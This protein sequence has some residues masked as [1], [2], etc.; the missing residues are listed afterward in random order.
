M[1]LRGS[2][3]PRSNEHPRGLNNIVLQSRVYRLPCDLSHWS[4][5]DLHDLI[6]PSARVGS[7][8]LVLSKSYISQKRVTSN[9]FERIQWTSIK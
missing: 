7:I 9:A 6:D 1:H 4:V 8:A 5:E 2:Y 3:G